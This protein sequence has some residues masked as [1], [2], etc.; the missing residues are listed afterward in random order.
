[1]QSVLDRY[2]S[3]KAGIWRGQLRFP[4]SFGRG[5][6]LFPHGKHG[7][8]NHWFGLR[9]INSTTFRKNL[10]PQ[11]SSPRSDEIEELQRLDRT[12]LAQLRTSRAA[13]LLPS[14]VEGHP[15]SKLDKRRYFSPTLTVLF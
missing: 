12:I 9:Q 1:M 7:L 10:G 8:H 4:Q 2:A 15:F 5:L 13:V 3:D 11:V 14:T 6:I